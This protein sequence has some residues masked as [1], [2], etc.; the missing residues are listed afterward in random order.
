MKYVLILTAA[1]L[2]SACSSTHK[3]DGDACCGGAKEASTHAP[4][5]ET[6][7]AATDAVTAGA[8]E[9][10]AKI[11][12]SQKAKLGKTCSAAAS[13][14]CGKVTRDLNITEGELSCL[15]GKVFRTTKEAIPDLDGS[16][17]AKLIKSAAASPA[18]VR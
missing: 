1:L 17:C 15:W 14:H 11:Y 18:K 7:T 5:A 16:A 10:I 13:A 12:T 8:K 2:V 3:K 9:E 4:A 6:A